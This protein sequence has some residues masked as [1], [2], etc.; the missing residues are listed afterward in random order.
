VI[1]VVK[2]LTTWYRKAG[3]TCQPYLWTVRSHI[4]KIN[5]ADIMQ[6]QDNDLSFYHLPGAE[7]YAQLMFTY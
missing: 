5:D 1:H 7:V 2:R 3:T 4:A 6:K